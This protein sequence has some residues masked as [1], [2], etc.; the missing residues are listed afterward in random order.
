[1]HVDQPEWGIIPSDLYKWGSIPYLPAPTLM[2]M[3][4]GP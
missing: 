4:N 2:C 3:A 1:M